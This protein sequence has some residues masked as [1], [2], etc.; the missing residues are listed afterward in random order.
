MIKVNAISKRFNDFEVFNDVSFTVNKGETVVIL[1]GSGCGKSTL[2]RCIN[3]LIEPEKGEIYIGEDNILAPKAN[4]DK[5]RRRMGMVYQQFNLFSHL[6]V[7]EN[8]MLAQMKVLKVDAKEAEEEAKRL[9]KLV[10]MQQHM[11]AMPDSLSGGQKQRVAIARTLAMK[12]DVILFDE[13]TSALDP[14]M[15]EEVENVIVDLS[16]SG[17]TSIIVTHEMGFARRIAS[18]V[19]FLAE[20]G[21]Y[22]EGKGSEIFDNPK[23]PLTRQFMYRSRMLE[24]NNITK[25]TDSNE[26]ITKIYEHIT[27]FDHD[28]RQFKIVRP[29]FDELIEPIL[30]AGATNATLRVICSET[31]KKH[32]IMI[33]F[34]KCNEDPLEKIDEINVKILESYSELMMSKKNSEDGYEVVIQ[35]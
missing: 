7:I 4:V 12:P 13:P 16:R 24:L 8:V 19:I 18:K 30:Q 11:L 6:S 31:S 3:K 20:K 17:M 25:E 15:V 26:S 9:L 29:L 27:K 28:T 32:M 2:L 22:E 35:M 34:E 23:R 21:I 33:D 14:T 10:G 1:G 5:I